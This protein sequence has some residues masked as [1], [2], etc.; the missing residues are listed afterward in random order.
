MGSRVVDD[1]RPLHSAGIVIDDVIYEDVAAGDVIHGK[2]AVGDLLAHVAKA[3]PTFKV[4]LQTSVMT[5]QMAAAEYVISSTQSGDLPYL[6]ATGKA[7]SIRA[8]SVFVVSAG[9]IQR[10]SRYYDMVQFLTQLG[11][12]D[13]ATMSQL[14]T[15]PA[16]PGG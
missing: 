13:A 11:G 9:L 2:A 8:S 12:L 4:T 6:A 7:F 16:Q 14:G 5:E 3:I 15:P 1:Q 10:E